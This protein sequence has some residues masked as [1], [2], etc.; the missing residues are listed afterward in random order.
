MK[1]VMGDVKLKSRLYL[2]NNGVNAEHE[3]FIKMEGK[4][5]FFRKVFHLFFTTN[6][7]LCIWIKS[8]EGASNL[9]GRYKGKMGHFAVI[10]FWCARLFHST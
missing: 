5:N 1:S 7:F 3:F 4:H 10:L 2:C 6:L 9:E 8:R